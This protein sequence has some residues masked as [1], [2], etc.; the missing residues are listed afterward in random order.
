MCYPAP[1]LTLTLFTIHPTLGR[2]DYTIYPTSLISMFTFTF[3]EHTKH[4]HW[5]RSEGFFGRFFPL[6]SFCSKDVLHDPRG[7][8]VWLMKSSI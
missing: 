8:T 4:L 2:H 1:R 7:W 6:I 3:T 5:R